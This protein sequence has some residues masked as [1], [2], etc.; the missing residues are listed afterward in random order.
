MS[1]IHLIII[2]ACI[3]GLVSILF[4][5]TSL[6]SKLSL[7]SAAQKAELEEI[8]KHKWLESEKVGYDIGFN[9]AQES[10]AVSHKHNWIKSRRFHV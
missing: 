4:V 5:D 2:C 10:W 3:S 7:N 6:C 1:N 8:K 9:N